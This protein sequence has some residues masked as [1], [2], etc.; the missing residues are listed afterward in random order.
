[1]PELK[2]SP[3]S[4]VAKPGTT[5]ADASSR[6]LVAGNVAQVADPMVTPEKSPETPTA[7]ADAPTNDVIATQPVSASA[8]PAASSGSMKSRLTPDSTAQE[9]SKDVEADSDKELAEK[10]LEKT[11]KELADEKQARLAEIIESHEYE[12]SI[13]QQKG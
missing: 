2:I 6:P 5:P 10:K 12:V 1:M 8:E 4:D 3:M 9:I 7:A 11:E 13:G